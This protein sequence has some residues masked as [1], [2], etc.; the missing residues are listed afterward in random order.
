MQWVKVRMSWAL[1]SG[2]RVKLISYALTLLFTKVR[3]ITFRIYCSRPEKCATS[4]RCNLR[5]TESCLHRH[6][7]DWC[8]AIQV[9]KLLLFQLW[10][11]RRN[12][13][14]FFFSL[15]LR[16]VDAKLSDSGNYSCHYS[17]A[18]EGDSVM[19]HVINGKCFLIRLSGWCML[20]LCWWNDG[21]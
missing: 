13:I 2:I 5:S 15:R 16:I 1:F 19:V 4:E 7:T 20:L 8:I 12:W 17:T 14:V 18:T 11:N 21:M 9:C 10:V 3:S 6:R